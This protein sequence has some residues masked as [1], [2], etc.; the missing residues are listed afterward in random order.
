[1][2]KVLIMGGSVF[3][4]RAIAKKFISMGDTVYVLNRGNHICPDGGIQLIADRNNFET[5]SEILK[6]YEFDIVVDGSAYN[7]AQTELL[8]KILKDRVKHF[9]HL[10]SASVYSDN[11]IFP[12]YEN[13]SRGQ[14]N[15]WGDYSKNKYLCEEFLFKMWDET[16]FPVTIIR[17]FYV[18][19][20]SNNLDRESYV[21]SRILNEKNIIIPN[22]GNPLIQFGHIDD[23]CDAVV[24]LCGNEKTF[25]EAY[26]VSGDEY[27]SLVGWVKL[28]AYILN[29]DAKIKLIDE[30]SYGYK[31]RD[32]F[33]FRAINF[34]GDC[35][36]IKTDVGFINKYSLCD[37]LK[38]TFFKKGADYYKNKYNENE[39]EGIINQIISR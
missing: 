15:S 34:I 36:K 14:H 16:K 21:F 35:S 22:R 10:S 11:G 8:F 12:F 2:R 31:A 19:G 33:P 3:I 27:I 1:M 18:Y 13:S 9:I 28:C 7:L 30:D 4:G 24:L 17:P 6:D 25:G 29:K 37:G 39:V 38:Q 23:L 20:P 26:N 5:M 32:W